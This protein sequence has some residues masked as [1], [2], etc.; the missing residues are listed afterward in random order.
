MSSANR[1]GSA[2]PEQ[3]VPVVPVTRQRAGACNAAGF[4][5]MVRDIP[6][7]LTARLSPSGRV[8]S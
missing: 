4:K 7:G 5:Y 6:S 1:H 8:I 2:R 3:N